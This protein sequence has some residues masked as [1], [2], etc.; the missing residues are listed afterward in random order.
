MILKYISWNQS[1]E[2]TIPMISEA[3][4]QEGYSKL[5]F[6]WPYGYHHG[7]VATTHEECFWLQRGEITFE[8]EGEKIEMRDGD[9]VYCPAGKK[10]EIKVHSL[11]GCFLFEGRKM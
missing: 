10:Y 3:I 8:C 1:I 5:V 6:S 9:K 7:P 11:T 4:N 2:P